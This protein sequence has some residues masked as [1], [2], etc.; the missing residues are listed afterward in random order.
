MIFVNPRKYNIDIVETENSEDRYKP[1]RGKMIREIRVKVLPPFG[2]SVNDTITYG[3]DSLQWIL[4]LANSIHQK[5]AERVIKKQMT[6]KPGMYIDPFELVQNEQLLKEMSN[7]DDALIGIERVAGDTTM[8][9]LVVVC[10]DEFSWTGEVWS[11]FLNSVDMGI[12]TKNLFKLG[13]A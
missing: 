13:H 12:E 6:V 11:N 1:Y 10:K 9:D 4:A 3:Q 5:S 7:V 2:T 8:V